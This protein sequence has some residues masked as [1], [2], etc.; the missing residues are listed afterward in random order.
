MVRNPATLRS[1]GYPRRGAQRW[2]LWQ[3]FAPQTD[4]PVSPLRPY[5]QW[6]QPVCWSWRLSH[7]ELQPSGNEH[8]GGAL[9]VA[10][11]VGNAAWRL[12]RAPAPW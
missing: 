12:T 2:K 3:Q 8:P 6:I 10:D 4:T 5:C 1:G 9:L 7:A 11:D